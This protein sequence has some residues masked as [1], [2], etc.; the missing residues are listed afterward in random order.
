M[1]FMRRH[2]FGHFV[3]L[4][5]Q[6][7]GTPSGFSFVFIEK[8]RCKNDFWGMSFGGSCFSVF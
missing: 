1:Q 8:K 5:E 7:R 4:A 3:G 2:P 6:E